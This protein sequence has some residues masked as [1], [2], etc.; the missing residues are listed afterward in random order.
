MLFLLLC[1]PGPAHAVKVAGVVCDA[2]GRPIPG[3]EVAVCPGCAPEEVTRLRAGKSGEF[4]ADVVECKSDAPGRLGVVYAYHPGYVPDWAELTPG[5]VRVVLQPAGQVWGT[6]VDEEGRPVRGAE[7]APMFVNL[8]GGK[9][10]SL[11]CSP[12]RDKLTATTTADGRWTISGLPL[13]GTAYVG[14]ADNRFAETSTMVMLGTDAVPAPPLVARPTAALVGRAVYENGKP[15][16]SV[17]IHCNGHRGGGTAAKTDAKGFY[18]LT[19]IG[20][21]LFD[22]MAKDPSGS[23]VG[24]ALG[25]VKATEGKITRLPDLVLTEGAVIKGQVLDAD[26]GKPIEGVYVGAFGTHNPS[27]TGVLQGTTTDAKGYYRL[28]VA[29]GE[30]TLSV[31]GTRRGYLREDRDE[32]P[33]RKAIARAGT[34]VCVDIRLKKGAEVTGVAVDASG[35]PVPGVDLGVKVELDKHGRNSVASSRTGPDGRFAISP[36]RPG[37]GSFT[38]GFNDFESVFFGEWEVVE[39][40]EVDVPSASPV[41]VTLRGVTRIPLVGR[42]VTPA[43]EPVAG[44]SVAVEIAVPMNPMTGMGG[45]VTWRTVTTTA[46][47]RFTIPDLRPSL[48][49]RIKSCEKPGHRYVW[50]GKVTAGE[51]F[52]VSDILMLRLGGQVRGRVVDSGNRPVAGAKV[53]C[54]ARGFAEPVVTDESGGFVLDSLPEGEAA[55]MAARGTAFGRTTAQAGSESVVIRLGE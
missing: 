55:I 2:D 22:V 12:F 7:V 48:E 32:Q 39:P 6:V 38:I 3:A 1:I 16:A 21:G 27:T 34:S 4:A 53:T 47:G 25:G 19:G 35:S 29:P 10:L 15:A 11:G 36:L 45:P 17:I 54:P 14:L 33:E 44:A 43:G 9:R 8:P 41:R 49:L 24:A 52:A 18:R 40:K 50:G 26:T 5:K 51:S 13:V 23:Y 37:R 42:V 30:T 31:D 28:R 46:D 20:T